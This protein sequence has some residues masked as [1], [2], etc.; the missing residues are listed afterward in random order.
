VE[1]S[2]PNIE[3]FRLPAEDFTAQT[4]QNKAQT[5]SLNRHSLNRNETL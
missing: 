1:K 5:S 2:P 3:L 4:K